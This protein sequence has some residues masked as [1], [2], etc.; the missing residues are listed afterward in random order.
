[1]ATFKEERLTKMKEQLGQVDQAITDVL[2]GGTTYTL[3]SG[4]TRQSVTRSTLTEL[5]NMQS[6]LTQEIESLDAAVNGSNGSVVYVR[7]GF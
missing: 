5:R 4:Q 3:D 7:P 2:G 1:M 6:Y